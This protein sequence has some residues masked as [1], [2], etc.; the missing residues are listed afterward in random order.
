MHMYTVAD[1]KV[2]PYEVN[3]SINAQDVCME[4]DTGAAVTVMN[5]QVWANIS[6]GT[7]LRELSPNKL[8]LKTYTGEEIPVQGD[9]VVPVTYQK[10]EYQ[11]PIVVVARG[12]G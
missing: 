6:T 4:I 8:R 10:V 2:K 7:I 5:E 1:T 3:F 9:T 11:L 12:T